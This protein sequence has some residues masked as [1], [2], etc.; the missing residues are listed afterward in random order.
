MNDMKYPPTAVGG[1]RLSSGGCCR[2]DLNET[3]TAVGW[4]LEAIF[5]SFTALGGIGF[6]CEASPRE[7]QV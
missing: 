3:P 1:I 7:I 2:Q 4:D 6:L 5:E